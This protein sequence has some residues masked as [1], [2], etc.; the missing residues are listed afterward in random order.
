MQPIRI[1]QHDLFDL[2]RQS[3]IDSSLPSAVSGFDDATSH[4]D[5]DGTCRMRQVPACHIW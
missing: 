2:F 4:E 3:K 5:F 1:A